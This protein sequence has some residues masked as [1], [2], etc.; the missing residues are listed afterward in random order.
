MITNSTIIGWFDP[1]KNQRRFY[2][3]YYV[4]KMLW[5]SNDFRGDIK[6]AL[7]RLILEAQFGDDSL[8]TSVRSSEKKKGSFI[9][10]VLLYG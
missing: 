2:V 10:K 8:A 4:W 9:M 5:F 1:P 3:W 6:F 7:I